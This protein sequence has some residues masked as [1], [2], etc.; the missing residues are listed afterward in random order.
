[1]TTIFFLFSLRASLSTG[2]ALLLFIRALEAAIL[3]TFAFGLD[4]GQTIHLL[5]VLSF[6]PDTLLIFGRCCAHGHSSSH[7]GLLSHYPPRSFTIPHAYLRAWTLHW[8]S[9]SDKSYLITITHSLYIRHS[10][11]AIRT[12]NQNHLCI[13]FA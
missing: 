1:M 12:T 13:H 5:D 4:N 2:L 8:T 11:F 3:G 10:D 6:R 9:P 7:L